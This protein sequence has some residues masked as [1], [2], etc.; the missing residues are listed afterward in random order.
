MSLPA[1]PAFHDLSR[2]DAPAQLAELARGH[3]SAAGQVQVGVC[4][5]MLAAVDTRLGWR[6]P[7]AGAGR[8][9]SARKA[10]VGAGPGLDGV[11]HGPPARG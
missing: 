11:G 10:G 3:L 5:R 6:P 7:G 2:A 1:A 9:T 4:L 8:F